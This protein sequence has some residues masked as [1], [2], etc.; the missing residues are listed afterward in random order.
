MTIGPCG[1]T[2]WTATEAAA[3]FGGTLSP[4]TLSPLTLAACLEL[5]RFLELATFLEMPPASVSSGR[6]E[7]RINEDPEDFTKCHR[8]THTRARRRLTNNSSILPSIQKSI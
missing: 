5:A 3:C 2:W 1:P 7:A 6:G 8:V 4:L